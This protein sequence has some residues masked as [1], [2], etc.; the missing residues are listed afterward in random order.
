MDSKQSEQRERNEESHRARFLTRRRFLLASGALAG[1]SVAGRPAQVSEGVARAAANPDEEPEPGE[2]DFLEGKFPGLTVYEADPENAEAAARETYIQPTT[3]R[4]EHYVRNH[5]LS[6]R[7]NEDEWTISLS[8]LIDEDAE[9]T[10]R[11][12]REDYSTA[13]IAHTMQCSGNGRAFFQPSIDGVP[14]RTG[15][16]GTA[17]WR[18]TPLSEILDEYGADTDKG[19]WLMVAGADHPE[20]E[21]IFARSIPMKKVMDDTILAYGMN[22]GPLTAEHGHPVRLIVPGWFGNNC[23]KWVA[24]MKVMETMVVGEEWKQYLEWQQNSYRML[25]EGQGPDHNASIKTFDTHEQMDAEAAGETTTAPYLYDQLVKSLIG[26]PRDNDTVRPRE[27]NGCVEVVGVAWAGDD[28]VETVEVSADGGQ[29]WEEA[30]LFGPDIGPAGWRQF[31][32][33]WE[34]EPG[35]YHLVSRATDEHGRTQPRNIVETNE[36]RQTVRDEKFPWN[37]GGYCCNAYMPHGVTVTVE[38]HP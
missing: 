12:L 16:V 15:A 8:G 20:D 38:D 28:A 17:V 25:T 32:Y 33:L 24:E 29:T 37:Q 26:H 21:D 2:R 13:S 7:I 6:P 1:A 31:R 22:E 3:P 18:G 19:T 10:M 23:V 27:Q 14:W 36:G 5:Y 30:E 11:E 9:L 35:I 34:S 4:E